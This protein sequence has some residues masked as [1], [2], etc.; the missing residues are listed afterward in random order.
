MVKEMRDY[1]NHTNWNKIYFQFIYAPMTHK[2]IPELRDTHVLLSFD[3]LVLI[4][5]VY[6]VTNIQC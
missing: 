5:F 1:N 2:H 3:R 6:R 4:R